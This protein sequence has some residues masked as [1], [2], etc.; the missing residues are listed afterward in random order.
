VR[1]AGF[2]TATLE[3]FSLSNIQFANAFPLWIEQRGE[4]I[5][6]AVTSCTAPFWPY[7]PDGAS[8]GMALDGAGR[9]TCKS[10]IKDTVI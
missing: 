8:G 3:S 4:D 7:A 6:A 2:I 10:G 9:A 1:R 5:V